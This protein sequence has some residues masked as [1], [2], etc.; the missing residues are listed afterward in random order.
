MAKK[1]LVVFFIISIIFQL[2][3]TVGLYLLVYVKPIPELISTG[4]EMLQQYNASP[5][6]PSAGTNLVRSFMVDTLQSERATATL[7][8]TI[9]TTLLICVLVQISVLITLFR[10]R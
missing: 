2:A 10:K 3:I 8:S 1:S 6:L 7:L 4:T 5:N 9:A